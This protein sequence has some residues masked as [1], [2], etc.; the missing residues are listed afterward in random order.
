M[1]ASN[2]SSDRSSVAELRRRP[3]I[4]ATIERENRENG[5]KTAIFPVFFLL[6][7]ILAL[8]TVPI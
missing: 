5:P 3:V 6:A 4:C 1:H 7:G 8:Q 2:S